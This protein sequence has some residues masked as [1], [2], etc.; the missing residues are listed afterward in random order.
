MNIEFIKTSSRPSSTTVSLIAD[1][2]QTQA[3]LDV[4]DATV[5]KIDA[6]QTVYLF[7]DVF[8]WL[9]EGKPKGVS[10]EHSALLKTIFQKNSLKDIV[11]RLE[12]EYIG[13][14]VNT[15]T[16]QVSVFADRY[17]R[18]DLFYATEGNTLV[19]SN[20]LNIIFQHVRPQY[21]Q[22]MLAHMVSV[23]GWYAPK[24]FTLY[25][26]VQRLKVGELLA[27]TAKGMKSE[28]IPFKPA[29]TEDYG[30][31]DLEKYYA[32][33]SHSIASRVGDSRDKIWVSSS[34][35]WDS[36][37]IL[38]LLVKM[39]GAKRI[40]MMTGSMQY[41]KTT[42]LIN[43][44]EINKIKKI[45]EFYGI[46]P[47]TVPL[48]FKNKSA[49]NYWKSI[50]PK[51]KDTH[52]YS[53]S[54]FNFCRISDG[55]AAADR[56]GRLVFNGETSDSFH[57][58]GFSQ[59]VTFFHTVKSF[60]EFGDKMNCYLYGP[61][62]LNKVLDGS[63]PK[64]KVFQ[65]FRAMMPGV[66]F[67]DNF[68][69]RNDM[70]QKYLFPLFYGGPRVP[71]A[72]SNVNPALKSNASGL[73]ATYLCKQYMPDVVKTLSPKNLYA[74]IIYMYH[75][76]HSQGSTVAIHR[77]A[78]SF[79]GHHCRSPFNDYQMIDLLSKAPESWGRGLDFN[80][81]KYPLKWV[82]Q[83]KVRFPYQLL[84]EGAHS[85]L[86]DVIEGFSLAAETLYRS[87]FTPYYKEVL[88]ARAYRS[89]FDPSYFDI[90][91]LDQLVDK[92]IDGKEVKGQDFNNTLTLLTL[93]SI[94]WY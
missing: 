10:T 26:N 72:K 74:W 66:Q 20:H 5:I 19:A 79:N 44:F 46:K 41:S 59:F 43:R 38:A 84:E 89:L 85:Y 92:F 54:G 33:L 47:Q 21:D 68:S 56:P 27:L 58:F 91:Y 73:V 57:N 60:T 94:G 63:Y 86:Y 78:M 42:G 34:S 40:G 7:G 28:Q 16:P 71:F 12:G 9:G 23:F 39:Y 1:L 81:T 8:Y 65:I 87:A 77:N 25:R 51:L 70:L 83:N 14:Y 90:K 18:L 31:P 36:S 82:A 75:S 4:T 2:G 48:D 62:F 6:T 64:D 11:Q 35:G 88:S 69:S 76:M 3:Y 13:F 29:Q 55:I 50:A 22:A 24:G 37:I 49:V 30:T 53:I 93:S 67:E 45:G 52:M 80:H 61:T 17:N 32:A 15:K